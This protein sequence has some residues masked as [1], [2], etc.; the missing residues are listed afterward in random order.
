MADEQPTRRRWGRGVAL[1][2]VAF[3]LLIATLGGYTIHETKK[4]AAEARR[5]LRGPSLELKPASIKAARDRVE[6][7]D[8]R[9]RGPIGTTLKLVPVIHQNVEAVQ[10]VASRT[11]PALTAAIHVVRRFHHL[12]KSRFLRR[13]KIN[14]S[15]LR[16]I[17][18]PLTQQHQKLKALL[19]ALRDS[20][21]HSLLPPVSHAFAELD[22]RVATFADETMRVRSVVAIAGPMLGDPQPRRYLVLL[23]NN[24]ESRGAGGIVSGAGTLQVSRGRLRLGRFYGHGVLADP[25]Y[26]TVPAPRDFRKRFGRF[27]ANTTKMVNATMSPDVPEVARVASRVLARTRG[28]RTQGAVIIDP[29]GI[30]ALLPAGERIPVAGTD[31]V[32]TPP[33]ISPFVYSGEYSQLGAGSAFR[34]DALLALGQTAF[35]DLT[36]AGG[37]GKLNIPTIRRA[38]A[39]GHIRVIS[40]KRREER[41]LTSLGVTGALPSRNRDRLLVTTQNFGGNKLDYWITR[42]VSH[43]C[44]LRKPGF[45]RCTTSVALRNTAP[46]NLIPYVAGRHP[47][48]LART[49]LDVYVPADARLTAVGL[50][51]HPARFGIDREDGLTA[52]GVVAKIL[53]GKSAHLNVTYRLALSGGDYSF[54]GVPQPLSRDATIRVVLILPSGATAT[55]GAGKLSGN[56]FSF[57]GPFTRPIEMHTSL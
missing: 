14:L 25:P 39:G 26:K 57:N 20:R 31:R 5:L 27:G 37:A 4:D 46:R 7:I 11:V 33:Q 8:D 52:I 36:Q 19:D 24:A 23:M 12:R 54:L 29:R 16:E 10:V 48:G 45:A 22:G 56:T 17:A 53:P 47:Y 51:G 6:A 3:A 38:V 2:V 40:F 9:L 35:A 21:R 15:L 13:G 41:V 28:I 49:L 43:T 34:H 55:G 50:D 1:L 18:R 42:Q 44:D 30:A 32:L